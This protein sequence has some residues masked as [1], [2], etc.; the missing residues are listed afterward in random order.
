MTDDLNTAEPIYPLRTKLAVRLILFTI[1]GW[2]AFFFV[3]ED[4]HLVPRPKTAKR[5]L[6][7]LGYSQ[8]RI[9]GVNPLRCADDDVFR[10]GFEAVSFAG[11]LVRGTVCQGWFKGATVR[12]R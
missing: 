5:I 12:L 4:L 10:T 2:F 3:V 8:V 6:E 9:T 11:K 1:L 7:S